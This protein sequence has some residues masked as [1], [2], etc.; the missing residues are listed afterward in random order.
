MP[1]SH[2]SEKFLLQLDNILLDLKKIST[3]NHKMI[4]IKDCFTIL[5]AWSKS[6]SLEVSVFITILREGAYYF[7]H[8]S[9]CEEG[10][11]RLIASDKTQ[12]SLRPL[13]MHVWA[14][15]CAVIINTMGTINGPV[16]FC[17]SGR[18]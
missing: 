10:S 15:L 6:I 4:D 8:V 12:H 17:D 5:F 14:K 3:A 2:F 18:R 9:P 11:E 16:T 7:Q 13:P 1:I